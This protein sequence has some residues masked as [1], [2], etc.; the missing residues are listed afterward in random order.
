MCRA[1]HQ[2][3]LSFPTEACQL[4]VKS[5]FSFATVWQLQATDDAARVW[6]TLMV[7]ACVSC[8][9]KAF[10]SLAFMAA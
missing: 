10:L 3:V 9:L 2:K 1:R 8:E 4:V 5:T 7:L 6:D